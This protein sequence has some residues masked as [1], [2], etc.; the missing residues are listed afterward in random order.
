MVSIVMAELTDMEGM[1]LQVWF[2][3]PVILLTLVLP[4]KVSYSKAREKKGRMLFPLV[5]D[6]IRLQLFSEAR[7]QIK[8]L[9]I[10]IEAYILI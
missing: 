4:G 9:E 1:Q 3:F 6:I 7:V 8:D 2:I 10:Y 5:S